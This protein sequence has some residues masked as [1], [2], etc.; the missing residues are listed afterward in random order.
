ML[1][2]VVDGKYVGG[3]ATLAAKLYQGRQDHEENTCVA[4]L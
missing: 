4:V 2:P 1:Q 3:L